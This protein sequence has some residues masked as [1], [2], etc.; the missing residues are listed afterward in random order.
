M[1]TLCFQSLP[2]VSMLKLDDNNQQQA[3]KTPFGILAFFAIFAILTYITSHQK[4]L[5]P[6]IKMTQMMKKIAPIILKYINFEEKKG[7]RYQFWP[8]Q[9]TFN[10]TY[11]WQIQFFHKIC[12][13]DLSF[14]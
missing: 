13:L 6:S 3:P 14:E 1:W 11:G 7:T 10:P 5:G 8:T 9:S 12:Y 2:E 4:L